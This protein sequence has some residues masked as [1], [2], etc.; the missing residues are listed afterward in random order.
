MA[1]IAINLLPI[2]FRIEETKSRKFLKIQTIGIAVVL[3]MVF[4]ASTTVALAILQ[5]KNISE[6]QSQV[7]AS[8]A[9]IESLKSTQGS[10]LLLKNRLTPIREYLGKPSLQTAMYDLTFKLLPETISINSISVD[11]GGEVLILATASDGDSLDRLITNLTS[12]ESNEGKIS[13]VSLESANRGKDGV[14]KVS[15]KIKP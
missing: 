11:K 1:K 15:L 7:A 6:I 9:R 12:K 2:E 13:Q 8:E 10:L 14:Y 5:S 4:L 3:L